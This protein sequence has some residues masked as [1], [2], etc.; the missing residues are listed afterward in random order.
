MVGVR[1]TLDPIKIMPLDLESQKQQFP[2]PDHEWGSS[3][4]E[5]LAGE[6][7]RLSHYPVASTQHQDPEE[8]HHGKLQISQPH[9]VVDNEI[10]GRN[11]NNCTVKINQ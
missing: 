3:F 4:R 10:L 2:I 11:F 8:I 7:H 5:V 6:K 9:L 1:D